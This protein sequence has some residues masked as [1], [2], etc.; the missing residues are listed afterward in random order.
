MKFITAKELMDTCSMLEKSG[1]SAV[2][3]VIADE[4]DD[5]TYH[6]IVDLIELAKSVNDLKNGHPKNY[7][8]FVTVFEEFK[9]KEGE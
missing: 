6:S 8:E 3:I 5:K 9:T 2:P 7:L 1:L 4:E